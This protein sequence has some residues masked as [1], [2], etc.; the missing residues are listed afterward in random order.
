MRDMMIHADYVNRRKG[1]NR[2]GQGTIGEGAPV[3]SRPLSLRR[4]G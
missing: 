3:C 4:T 1:E 2:N